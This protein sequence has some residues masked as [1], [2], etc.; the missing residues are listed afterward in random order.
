MTMSR[1]QT[2]LLADQQIPLTGRSLWNGEHIAGNVE[3][4]ARAPHLANLTAVAKSPS[5]GSSEANITPESIL[6]F[7]LN[8]PESVAEGD[9]VVVI[10]VFRAFTVAAL[11]LKRGAS[12]IIM[13]D[14]VEQALS[15][16]K[17]LPMAICMGERNGKKIGSFQLGNSPQDLLDYPIRGRTLVQTTSNGTRGIVSSSVSARVYAASLVNIEATA[18]CIARRYNGERII[19]VAM[20]NGSRTRMDEDELCSFYLRSLLLGAQPDKRCLVDYLMSIASHS[21][22]VDKRD[23]PMSPGD[24]ELC[25]QVGSI[26]AAI[27]VRQIDGLLHAQ[28]ERT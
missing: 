8:P 6:L 17:R 23:T 3:I 14:S 2:A 10:D 28:E 21:H 4:K 26:D 11:A 20:G 9:I 16:R 27:R 13:V 5:G 7:S 19:I 22:L 18:K 1:R 12:Q 25:L 24:L 15:L